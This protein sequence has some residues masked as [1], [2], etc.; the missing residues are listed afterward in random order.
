MLALC[1]PFGKTDFT[2][3]KQ[4]RDSHIA[5]P[6]LLEWEDSTTIDPDRKG[7]VQ[8]SEGEDSS[9]GHW[10]NHTGQCDD[11]GLLWR[12]MKFPTKA[13]SQKSCFPNRK[14][15][16]AETSSTAS[17]ASTSSEKPQEQTLRIKIRSSGERSSWLLPRTI[18][19]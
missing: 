19:M 8:A 3:R 2:E 11:D 14:A 13:A 16:V 9:R 10:T 5:R 12:S 6:S 7:W 15:G 17:P 18:T 4:A 1:I